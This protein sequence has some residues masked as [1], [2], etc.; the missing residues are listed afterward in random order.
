MLTKQ[1]QDLEARGTSLAEIAV[2]LNIPLTEVLKNRD[3]KKPLFPEVKVEAKPEKPSVPIVEPA[4]NALKAKVDKAAL[5][6]IEALT[7]AIKNSDA[8]ELAKISDAISKL[9]TTFFKAD[10]STV[11]NIQTNQLSKFRSVL[12]D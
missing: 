3:S 6:A 1:I 9:H 4:E 12:K 11:V 5:V 10:A 2:E 7:S 8:Q